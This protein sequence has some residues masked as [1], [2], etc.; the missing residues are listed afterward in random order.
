MKYEIYFDESNKLDQKTDNYS[1]YG[2]LGASIQ[3]I[4][5]LN[6]NVSQ[7]NGSLNSKSELHF[8]NYTND[9]KFIKYFEV[10]SYVLNQDIKINIMIVD[11]NDAKEIAEKMNI[12]IVEL[13][14]LFYVKIPERLF[15]GLARNL[16]SNESIDIII[17]ENSEYEKINL[18]TKLEEQMNAH[19][20]Y[21]NKGYKVSSVKQKS[22]ENEIPL[23]IIDTIMG[24]IVFLV[25][26][27]FEEQSSKA[28]IIKSDLIYRLLIHNNNL[29]KLHNLVNLYKWNNKSED[30]TLLDLS[31]YTGS[32]IIMKAE[33]DIKEITR[34]SKIMAKYPNK[35]TK[36]YRE[37]MKY[38]NRQLR[39]LKGYISEL[40]D[41][42]RN[43][44]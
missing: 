17:D 27:N 5:K 25:E 37:K 2:A 44:F 23:Q 4:D 15:Y 38:S 31:K 39:Q 35:V 7:I 30:I 9:D 24:I 14:E 20:V 21:R 26:R 43:N 18:M 16:N 32:F 29:E 34:L 41:K 28:K 33:Y 13:R 22:S 3:I 40:E 1:Y 36:F 19:S 12:S 8:V 42:G 11:N 6:D 10:I